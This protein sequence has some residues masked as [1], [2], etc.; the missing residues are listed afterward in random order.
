MALVAPLDE[1]I[2]AAHRIRAFTE[3]LDVQENT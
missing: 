3:Q 1:C 2:D